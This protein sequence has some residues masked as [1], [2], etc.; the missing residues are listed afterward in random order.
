MGPNDDCDLFGGP[1]LPSLLP[2][3][4][5]FSVGAS[6]T[7][8]DPEVHTPF[9]RTR[10]LAMA[11]GAKRRP[12]GS[13]SEE[14]KRRRNL[15]RVQVVGERPEVERRLEELVF[16]G[17]DALLERLQPAQYEDRSLLGEDSSDSELENEAKG[18]LPPRKKAAWVDE[19]DG[20]EDQV[21]MT[22]RFRKN[23][24]KSANEKTLTVAKLH[25]RLKNEFQ[26]A[27]GGI[28]SWAERK[29]KKKKKDKKDSSEESDNDDE[30]L[31]RKT[32]NFVSTS[33]ALPK[34]LLQIKS[35]TNANRT[36]PS[37]CSLTTTQF[38]PLAQVILT[39]GK[40]QAISLFQ[41]DGKTNPKIQSICLENFPVHKARFS[42]DGEQV[43]ATS[44]RGKLFYIYDMM[45]GKVIPFN[46]VRGLQ[47]QNVNKFQVSPDGSFLMFI[48]TAGYLHLLTMKTKE[49]VGNMKINGQ[50]IGATFSP[51][52]SMVYVNSDDGQV[53][54]WDVK[55]RR[56]VNR[57]TDEGCL[58]GTCISVSHNG[59]YVA[60]GSSSG[61][62]NVYSRNSCLNETSPKPIKAI[63]NLVTSVSSLTFNP[64]TEILAIASKETKDAVKMIHIPSFTAFSNFPMYRQI[65][66]HFTQDMDFSPRSGFFSIANNLGRA[67]LY[68]VKH[69][70]DF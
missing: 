69:Y 33:A 15:Q 64:T 41:V 6:R 14:A 59:Q 8:S 28:P 42:T 36:R 21:E 53:Y 57:F 49:L 54:V 50:A 35:C 3:P 39:A 70:A 4:P 27:M 5:H 17:E 26:S 52:G 68:R 13:A 31:L 1:T 48:G 11:D 60:C 25:Q 38:H 30:D 51:D 67:L 7:P 34:G 63:M 56:C 47:E 2:L 24:Q 43:I 19:E 46:N 61:V 16:G 37:L 9:P 58:R 18:S 22:H 65:R 40:D 32:G 66:I 23:L 10:F 44:S 20:M 62:V 29:D 12:E 45:A 55:S